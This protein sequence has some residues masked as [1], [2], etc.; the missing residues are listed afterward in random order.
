M[1]DGWDLA[2]QTATASGVCI[3]ALEAL[4]DTPA[5]NEVIAQIWGGQALGHEILQALQHAGCVFFGARAADAAGHDDPLIGYVLGFV[6]PEH[7]LHVHSHMLAV[8]PDWQRRGV[9]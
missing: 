6:G 8:V 7:G 3:V 1:S 5:V 2:E 4:R 9:G